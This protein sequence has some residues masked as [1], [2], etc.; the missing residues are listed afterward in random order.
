MKNPIPIIKRVSFTGKQLVELEKA[1]QSNENI[2]EFERKK[3][4]E[5]LE[6]T[7]KQIITWVKNKKNRMFNGEK[8]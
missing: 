2:S 5:K 6:L 1:F 8:S 3:L 7:E 4:A